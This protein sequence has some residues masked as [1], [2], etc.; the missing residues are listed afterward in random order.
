MNVQSRADFQ[1]E[2]KV[3]PALA[4]QL[5]GRHAMAEIAT[6]MGL[7]RSALV[8]LMNRAMTSLGKNLAEPE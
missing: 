2:M 6:A 1:R 7:T 3:R 5:L 8:W 4:I